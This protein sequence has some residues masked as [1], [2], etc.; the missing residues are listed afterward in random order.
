MK[1][2]EIIIKDENLDDLKEILTECNATDI[3][4]SKTKHYD[5]QKGYKKICRGT[6]Y[7]VDLLR[8]VKAEIIVT[9][10]VSELIIDKVL[11]EINNGNYKECKIFSSDIEDVVKI[12]V[13][14]HGFYAL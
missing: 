1:K 8:R 5:N 13:A 12:H 2:L 10:E 3:M 4:I 7:Y 11:K 9:P 6:E 14:K